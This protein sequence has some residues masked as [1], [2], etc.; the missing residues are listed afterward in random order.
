MHLTVALNP[1]VAPTYP[2]PIDL[3]YLHDGASRTVRV[4]VR[5][6]D[7]LD[8]VQVL[9]HCYLANLTAMK[10]G[11]RLRKW[12]R[13][14]MRLIGPSRAKVTITGI[15]ATSS[16]HPFGWHVDPGETDTFEVWVERLPHGKRISTTGLV[17]SYR[18]R[19]HGERGSLTFNAYAVAKR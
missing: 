9:P 8:G 12:T 14:M 1:R 3:E 4:P 11:E 13:S 19:E 5:K 17:V 2:R 15:R 10:R 18:D 16:D 6:I 7:R